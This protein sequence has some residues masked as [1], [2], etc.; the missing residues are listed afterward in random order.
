M[1]WVDF[2][3]SLSEFWA[4]FKRQKTGLLGIFLLALLI[5]TALAAPIL[6]SPDIPEKWKTFWL[7]NPKNVPPTWVNVFSS[8]KLAP[9]L[10][11]EG[12]ELQKYLKQTDSGYVIEIPYNNEYDVP[13][14]DIV[15]KDVVGKSEGIRKPTLTVKVKRPDGTEVVLLQNYKFSGNTVIQLG[16]NPAVRDALIR[17]VKSQGIQIDPTKEFQ[18]KTLMD[19]TRVIF[20][21]LNEN[22]LE[23][24]EP[25]QGT[26]TFIF[27]IN[28]PKDASVDL[29]NAKIIFTGRTYGW[30]GTDFKGRD[31]L[32]G[33]IW[34]SRVSLAIGVSVAVFSVLIGIFYGV[35]SAYFGGWTD[36]MMMRFQEFMASIPSL[37]ILILMSTYFG[38]HISLW[39]IVLLLVVFGWVGVARVARSMALQIKEQTYVEAARVL[40]ASTGRIIF[41]HMVPQ[42]L[43]YAFASMAL[44]VPGA[45]LSE[46]SLSFLG[47]GDPTAVTWGQIL[48][49]AQAAG[50]A[51]NGYWWWVL[52]P[53]L[54][55]ALVGFTFVMIGTALDRVLNPR[56]RRM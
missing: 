46:A 20:G 41:K 27:E 19:A 54:A 8:Q 29:D 50:A 18:Y 15:F 43:P 10:V 52:P 34:G 21:K 53:G 32:A 36:E 56:L 11:L 7:D 55:I 13:P 31:L 40:G 35:T 30:L 3:E 4:D 38:G 47:L 25:L 33:I 37:P 2:K 17:W 51:T 24:P 49:D 42:L 14:Q 9:H 28:V 5:F 22:I 1:R 12:S 44:G 26:Y 45:V 16:T 6:T 23:K 39:Q 48:H